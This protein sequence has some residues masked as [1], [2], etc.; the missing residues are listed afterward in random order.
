MAEE[1]EFLRKRSVEFYHNACTL[2]QIKKEIV[3]EKEKYLK[4]YIFG[5][6]NKTEYICIK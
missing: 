4:N 1:I 3:E 6:K 2:T 5:V